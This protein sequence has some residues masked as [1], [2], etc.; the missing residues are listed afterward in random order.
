MGKQIEFQLSAID[1]DATKK[2]VEE[3]LEKYR[4][5]L[6]TQTLDQLPKITSS[7][8]LVPPTN[9]NQFN[10]S[11]ESA[12]IENANYESERKKYIKKIS[13][14]VNRLAYKE[15]QIIIKRYMA[16]NDVYDYEVYNELS[17]SERTYHRYKSK[18]FYKLAFALGIEVYVNE[19]VTGV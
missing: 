12:A 2:E 3:A 11:T 8:N 15:R 18:A 6:L 16:D 5:M 9:T 14:S 13:L 7:F 19:A 1:R 10:S 4:I 17:M